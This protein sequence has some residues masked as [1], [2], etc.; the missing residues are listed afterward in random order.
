MRVRVFNP[1]RNIIEEVTPL[2]QDSRRI[3]HVVIVGKDLLLVEPADY[4]RV[5]M[6]TG[7]PQENITYYRAFGHQ[8]NDIT[9]QV[10][11]R[12]VAGDWKIEA[13]LSLLTRAFSESI[14]PSGQEY[15]F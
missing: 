1:S 14:T 13:R 15:S 8:V 4:Y 3:I 9:D 2:A 12:K 11:A 5:R 6:I 7:H 10:S